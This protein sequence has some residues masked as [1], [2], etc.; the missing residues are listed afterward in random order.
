VWWAGAATWKPFRLRG[1]CSSTAARHSLTGPCGISGAR[2]ASR[3]RRNR[4]RGEDYEREDQALK[5]LRDALHMGVRAYVGAPSESDG[6]PS[7]CASSPP[8]RLVSVSARTRRLERSEMAQDQ[9]AH[10]PPAWAV[11]GDFGPKRRSEPADALTAASRRQDERLE[12]SADGIGPAVAEHQWDA[13]GGFDGSVGF[14]PGRS[15][16]SGR[17]R[18]G[19]V[20]PVTR[21]DSVRRCLCLTQAPLRTPGR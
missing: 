20:Q 2:P 7:Y 10:R 19:G 1:R 17:R 8:G 11:E 6:S 21:N 13:T 5:P 4:I 14:D 12:S 16:L 18:S 3:R 15:R 9:V